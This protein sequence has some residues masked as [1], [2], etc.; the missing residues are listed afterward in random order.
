MNFNAEDVRPARRP[1]FDFTRFL[2]IVAVVCAVAARPAAAKE[3]TEHAREFREQLLGSVLPYWYDTAVD[4]KRGGYLLS[5][6]AT[7]TAPPASDRMIVTQ[8]RMVWGFSHVFNQGYRD[9]QRD[10]VKAARVGYEYLVAHF[11]DPQNGGYYWK[12]D[13]E[14]KPINDRKYLYGQAFV[15]YAFVE[16]YRASHDREAL[17]RAL[18]LYR[19]IQLNC[20]DVEHGGWGE[21]YT[22]DW[23]LITRQDDRIEIEL[24]GLKSANSHL[25]WME[26]LTELYDATRNDDVKTS[27]AEALRINTTYFYPAQPDRCAFHRNPD[28]S[29]VTDPHSAGLSYGHN[30]EF[31]WLM[32]R[33][34]RALGQTPAWDHFSALLEHALAH[35]FDRERGGLYSR[36]IQDLAATDTDK[37][38]WAQAEMLAALTVSLHHEWDIRQEQ[39][40][41]KL[42]N[43]LQAFVIDERDGIW[44]ESVTADGHPRSQSKANDWKANYHDVRALVMFV[45]EFGQAP[46]R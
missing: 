9:P 25:H 29:F 39:A 12:T 4:W 23:I 20:H 7:K 45:E 19:A 40:L 17:E 10:Y 26:A 8:A 11:L 42:I 18:S 34:Q 41:H 27:L 22:A 28:W 43:F 44:I 35:G 21:H 24:A 36:G 15:I 5:D 13:L 37:V 33:A 16:Y 2:L 14:G 6:N 31:A 30:V 1:A 32:V 46:Q 38:W 3:L